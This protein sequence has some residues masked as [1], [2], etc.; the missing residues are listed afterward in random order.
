MEITRKGILLEYLQREKMGLA[1]CSRNARGLE[2]IRGFEE[3]FDRS[4]KRCRIVRELIQALE[5]NEVEDAMMRWQTRA[6][7]PRGGMD[8]LA[9]ENMPQE[10]TPIRPVT[11]I[12]V[13]YSWAGENT[14]GQTVM[15]F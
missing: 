6:G 14:E 5:S 4:E 15:R 8:E 9:E 10:P 1:S 3:E 7:I 12:P 13:S 11:P 2:P